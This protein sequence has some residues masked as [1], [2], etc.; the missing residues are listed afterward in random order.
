M[1]EDLLGTRCTAGQEDE[2]TLCGW[3][4][5][6]TYCQTCDGWYGVSHEGI[7][8]G[9]MAHPRSLHEARQCACRPCREYVTSFEAT[10]GPI[11]PVVRVVRRL[12]LERD[13]DVSGI[14]GV[15]VVAYGVEF[16]DGS[17]VLRW[18]TKVR[19]TVFYD[20]LADLE[21]ITGHGGRTRIVYDD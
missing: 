17:I 20:N 11:R 2:P 4:H 3:H 6:H 18:D 10:A 5:S 13:E 8:N 7:H 19:S 15:G 1:S 16:P 21:T 12:H 9:P 14:S